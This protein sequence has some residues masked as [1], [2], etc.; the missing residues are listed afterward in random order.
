MGHYYIT[1]PTKVKKKF[2]KR[3]KKG[4]RLLVPLPIENQSIRFLAER[5]SAS[6]SHP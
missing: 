5:N 1:I 4:E 6:Q 2:E 3:I